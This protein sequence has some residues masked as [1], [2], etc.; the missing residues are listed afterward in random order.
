MAVLDPVKLVID[1][2][3]EGQMEDTDGC[4]IIWRIRSSG[5]A[6]VVPFW[7]ESFTL[8]GKTLWRSL[9]RNTSACSQAMRS[10]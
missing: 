2:Y 8:S 5:R 3:P 9:R 10:A 7:Q 4:R 1:N 6:A